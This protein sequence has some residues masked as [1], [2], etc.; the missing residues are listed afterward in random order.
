MT[1]FMN[2]PLQERKRD[3]VRDER[4]RGEVSDDTGLDDDP[5]PLGVGVD[6]DRSDLH[7][8]ANF[9]VQL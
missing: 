8:H 3:H 2:D 1:S 5:D 9:P 4:V 7:S 6:D